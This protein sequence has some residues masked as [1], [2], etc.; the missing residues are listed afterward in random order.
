MAPRRAARGTRPKGK[1]HTMRQ[2]KSRGTRARSPEA[3]VQRPLGPFRNSSE[4]RSGKRPG[5]D[6]WRELETEP[7]ARLGHW[8][9][10]QGAGIRGF[11]RNKQDPPREPGRMGAGIQAGKVS[12]QAGGRR[13]RPEWSQREGY[14]KP[15]SGAPRTGTGRAGKRGTPDKSGRPPIKHQGRVHQGHLKSQERIPENNLEQSP[16]RSQGGLA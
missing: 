7:G 5:R 11:S 4:G 6:P 13:G 2:I 8:K 1:Q 15:T 3:S 10:R 9:S 12:L 14:Q 16:E